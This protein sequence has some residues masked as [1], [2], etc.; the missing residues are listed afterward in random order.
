MEAITTKEELIKNLEKIERYLQ[1][2]QEDIFDEMA[3]YIARGK[4]FVAYFV[5]G[6]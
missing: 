6:Q 5:E 1:S 2:E 3:R 4:C